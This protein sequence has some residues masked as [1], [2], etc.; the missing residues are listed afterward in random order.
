MSSSRYR[1]F[2][3]RTELVLGFLVLLAALGSSLGARAAEAGTPDRPGPSL[4]IIGGEK[5]P[6][7]GS[8]WMVALSDRWV[9]GWRH[10][11][12]C[13]GAL[14]AP[15]WVVTAEH[16]LWGMSRRRVEVF[17]GAGRL[18]TDLEGGI[19]IRGIR[20]SRVPGFDVALLHLESRSGR[21]PLEVVG[22]MP[23]S[24]SVGTALGW[25][26]V[27]RGS[28]IVDRLR[29]VEVEVRSTADCQAA[30][31][32]A[33][34]PATMLCAGG[35]GRDTCAGDSGGPLVFD[36]RLIGITSFG[37]G[38]GRW[39]GVYARADRLA[40]WLETTVRRDTLRHRRQ[41]LR[42]RKAAKARAAA[43]ARAESPR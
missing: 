2:R 33:F 14:V 35:Q 20:R 39:P 38:C 34:D 27:G 30:Y 29:Q 24:G 18:S 37:R 16:C 22:E 15:D 12:F 9:S 7:G 5:A 32:G 3:I 25:G 43:R 6:A 40:G 42:A 13:G 8:P 17:P 21:Q 19:G 23:E 4:R 41:A 1:T 11:V 31:F 26:V 28:G 36:G 10:S